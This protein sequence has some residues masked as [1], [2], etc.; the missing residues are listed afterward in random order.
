MTV[1]IGKIMNELREKIEKA[2]YYTRLKNKET[3][4]VI[5]LP[6]PVSRVSIK[7]NSNNEYEVKLIPGGDQYKM[8]LETIQELLS[9]L[10]ANLYFDDSGLYF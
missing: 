10:Y 3:L 2:G 4:Y 9:Y 1:H 5:S 6:Y 7:I 8:T